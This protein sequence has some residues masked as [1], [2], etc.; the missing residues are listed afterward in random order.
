MSKNQYQF[1]KELARRVLLESGARGLPVDVW[2]IC[3]RCGIITATYR[4]EKKSPGC[5][6]V[7]EGVPMIF[8]DERM[9]EEKQR[10]VCAHELGHILMGHVGAWGCIADSRDLPRFIKEHAA[11]VF[12]VEL[13]YSTGSSCS[14]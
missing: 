7:Y 8:V 5:C 9:R 12:A 4:S 10:F 6:F 1:A 11:M 14:F 13:P 2:D 3:E